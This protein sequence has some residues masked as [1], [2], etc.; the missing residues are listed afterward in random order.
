MNLSTRQIAKEYA[1]YTRTLLFLTGRAGTGKTTLLKEILEET[2]KKTIVVAPTGVAAINAGGMTIHSMFQLPTTGFVPTDDMVDPD[3]FTN[4]K[5]LAKTQKIRKERIQVILELELL[6]IDEISM[7]RADLLDAIDATLCR[8][9]K[10]SLPFGGV[11][12]MVIGD[13]FQLSPVVRNDAFR[14]LSNYYESPY[15]FD[16]WVWKRA[17]TITL[18]LTKIYRQDDTVFINILNNIRQGNKIN[19]DL[20]ILNKR[21]AKADPKANI[22]TLTTHNAKALKINKEALDALK[23]EV[24]K[25]EADIKGRFS[26][27]A[28]PADEE[29][30]L[31]KGSQVMFVRNHSEGAYYNGKIGEV[32]GMHEDDVFVKCKGDS[33][34][35]RVQPV[36]WKNVKY[37]VDKETKAVLKE[38]IGSF[39]Q[40]PL[41]LAW[42]VTVHKSQGL[43]FE[44]VTLDLANTFAPGQLYVALSRCISMEGLYL[45]A[46][47]TTSNIII[48]D[49]IKN[50]YLNHTTDL[51]D[52]DHL[53]KA[54]ADYEDI[55]ILE[56]WNLTKLSTYA[57]MWHETIDESNLP[58]ENKIY[59]VTQKVESALDV[60]IKTS[61]KFQ[62]QLKSLISEYKEDDEQLH[63]IIERCQK[64][65]VYFTKELHEK[66]ITPLSEHYSEYKLKGKVKKYLTVVESLLNDAW[67]K[68]NELYL[69]E[70]RGIKV[71]PE[72]RA[73]KRIVLFDPDKKMVK[74]EKGATYLVT[75]DLLNDDKSIQEIAE[76]R[77]LA[78]GTI[79]GH[80]DKLLKDDKISIDQIMPHDRQEKL[81]PY[82]RNNPEGT[83]ITDIRSKMSFEVSFGELRW[84]QTMI[85][86]EKSEEEEAAQKNSPK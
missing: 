35:I 47:V 67:L 32:T 82:F 27:S 31:K 39:T 76:I 77:S 57:E 68:M 74:K 40:Y 58:N 44:Q 8:I 59:K 24:Y 25:L 56:K 79:E 62:W 13:L 55:K 37:T 64:A 29:I 16:S 84:I 12:V 2:S 42:A 86:K 14:T 70:Y 63:Q 3:Q 34:P 80:F 38:D 1:L 72:P 30:T 61:E 33:G 21:V 75:L 7:V 46:P 20:D 66:V 43:T 50:Y 5:R 41:K 23:T 78:V 85:A 52:T 11:Q 60:L 69:I 54:K 48:D 65:V 4:R 51:I 26:E 10:S 45:T 71:H 19:E 9:R 49:R 73:Y 22:I 36:E 81:I 18:E 15:F 17:A 83:T 6:V 28:Y 53:A